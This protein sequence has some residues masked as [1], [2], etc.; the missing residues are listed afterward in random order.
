MASMILLVEG[1]L[2]GSGIVQTLSLIN[3]YI[4]F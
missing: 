2:I 1:E 4:I 3:A